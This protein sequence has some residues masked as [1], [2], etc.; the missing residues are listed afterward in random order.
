MSG[1]RTS[2]SLPP[3]GG[4]LGRGVRPCRLPPTPCSVPA[5]ERRARLARFVS[6]RRREQRRIGPQPRIGLDRVGVDAERFRHALGQ[7]GEFHRLREGDQRTRSPPSSRL[8][9]RGT[10]GR[11][12]TRAPPGQSRMTSRFDIRACSANS[13]SDCAALVLLDLR[14][15][16]EQRFEVAVFADELRRGLDA[17]AGHS[18]HVVGGV[19]DQ[20]LHVRHLRGRHAE[21]LDDEGLR[22]RGA[23]FPAS[24]RTS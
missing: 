18:R 14:R 3:C 6:G 23:H 20:R 12:G 7:A 17:D 5:P 8:R 19:A 22:R 15:A 10:G 4:G 13:I 11:A 24:G 21:L 1:A 16:G 9:R 2:R